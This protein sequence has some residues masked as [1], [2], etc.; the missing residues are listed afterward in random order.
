M[1]NKKNVISLYLSELLPSVFAWILGIK[2]NSF[3]KK[4]K[5]NGDKINSPITCIFSFK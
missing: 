2:A 5:R 1:R 3:I 4:L